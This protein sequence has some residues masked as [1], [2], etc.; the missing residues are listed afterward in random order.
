[1][2]WPDDA[3][4]QGMCAGGHGGATRRGWEGKGKWMRSRGQAAWSVDRWLRRTAQDGMGRKRMSAVR[5]GSATVAPK[6]AVSG[7][8]RD[9]ATRLSLLFV[10]LSIS[11][12]GRTRSSPPLVLFIGRSQWAVSSTCGLQLYHRRDGWMGLD[13]ASP[14]PF[15]WHQCG[16]RGERTPEKAWEGVDFLSFHSRGR[17]LWELGQD[18]GEGQLKDGQA[19]GGREPR[20]VLRT[21]DARGGFLRRYH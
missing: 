5:D 18:G 11:P 12:A 6:H 20:D 13:W 10:G 15:S 9:T 16:V 4:G 8:E 2:D 1:M 21:M 19:G 14:P 3:G 7:P 17:R